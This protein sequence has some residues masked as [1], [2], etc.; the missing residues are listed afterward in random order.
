MVIYDD[1]DDYYEEEED[2]FDGWS[3]SPVWLSRII[4]P[5]KSYEYTYEENE[6]LNE[7]IN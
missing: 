4:I 2:V 1:E 5:M 7:Y 3:S 6:Y